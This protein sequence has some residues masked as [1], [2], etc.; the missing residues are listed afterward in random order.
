MI[1]ILAIDDNKD[2]LVFLTS[3]LSAA[4]PDAKVI[5]SQSGIG[6]IEKAREEKP[7]V[8]LLVMSS[9]NGFETCKKMKGYDL[10]KRV[11]VIMITASEANT[12]IRIE[13]LESG[14]GAFL[15]KPIDEA[16][17]S[18]LVYSMIRLKKSEDQVR[19]ET[20]R[21]KELVNERTKALEKSKHEV[22]NL[23]KG[24]KAEIEHSK[25]LEEALL[26][27]D[28]QFD[29]LYRDTPVGLYRATPDGKILLANRA[30]YEMLGYSTLK[31]ISARDLEENG[32]EPSYRRQ[33]FMEQIEKNGEVKDLES[34][35]I[36]CNGEV[37]IVR[38]N[39]KV[40]R[41]SDGKPIYYD[42]TVEDITGRKRAEEALVKQ[43][44]ALS[45]LN[46]FSLGLT[47]LAPEDKLE[48]FITKQIKEF[49]GAE[50]AVFSEYNPANRTTT[51]QHIE[52]ESGPHEK[53]VNLLGKHVKEIQ[54]VVSDEMY[55]EM[56]TERIGTKATL[57]E[58]TF[59]AVSRSVGATI[60]ALLKVDRFIGLA[61]L[62]NGKLYGTSLLAMK[63]GQ[64]DPPKKILEN[65]VFLS[66]MFMRRK[67]A[68]KELI[69]A[70]GKAE[71]SDRLKSA[72][73]TNVSHEIRTP[74]NGILGFA[75]LLKEPGLTGG[76][77]QEYIRLIEKSG[78]RMLNIIDDIV[79]LSEIES[80]QVKVSVSE[81]NVNGEIIDIY[82]FFKPEAEQKGLQI[83]YKNALPA[84]EA[85]IK[86]DQNK[87]FAILSNLV[88]N[89]IKFTN[90]GSIEFGYEKKDK[91][92]EF[93]IKDSGIGILPEHS[94]FIFEKFRQV[95]ESLS[96]AYQGAGLGLA[97]S[98]AY[99]E[100][101]GGRIWVESDPESKSGGKGST[102]YFTIPVNAQS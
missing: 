90:Q 4:F 83:Y 33:Q 68:E 45:K 65:F 22:L 21:F 89:A 25:L 3:F 35:W 52:M 10:L 55:Q 78:A 29:N 26:Y 86:T 36:C 31:G 17:L 67:Q 84:N 64:P 34:K 1:K 60:Q 11:P 79:N 49:S 94:E 63:K 102:F 98:K 5:T 59:G 54:T 61:F 37:I 14:A 15:S 80:G 87:L 58:A 2:N 12:S 100:I 8:I 53:V 70:K 7:D 71:E 23:L 88:K 66:A 19:L 77:Q 30:I 46:H 82:T 91:Y 18:T 38:E 28:E 51:T 97:I 48:A 47:M 41:D 9:T 99:V 62:V 92:L 75:E 50:V 95:N 13:G 6:G 69:I 73:L 81:T 101:L 44:D 57:H 27:S 74:M 16:E 72:F 85:I 32:F 20:I 24:L 93:F 96:R 42:G 40:I 43:N 39:A 76:D 56:I